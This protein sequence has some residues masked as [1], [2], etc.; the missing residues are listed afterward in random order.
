MEQLLD[1]VFWHAMVGSQADI[2]SGSGSSRRY[3]RGYSPIAAFADPLHANFEALEGEFEPGER[4]YT[5]AWSGPVPGGWRLEFESYMEKMVWDGAA[6]PTADAPGAVP[7]RTEH[8]AQALVLAELTR[9]GPF[10]LRTIEMGSYLGL[11]EDGRLIAMAG[12]RACA[13]NLREVSGICTHPE[14]QGRGLAKRLTAM[15]IR[16]IL[17][18]GETPFLHVVGGNH[19]AHDFY[20]KL[21]FR[22]FHTSTVRILVRE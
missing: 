12:E 8:A 20:R 16:H 2:A 14:F 17:A 10:G 5:D 13:G 4:F 9:P 11:V 19:T 22:D 21:G 18:R 3:A 7:L 6:A 1:N 15:V